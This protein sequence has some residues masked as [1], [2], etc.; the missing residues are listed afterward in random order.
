MC[1]LFTKY[2]LVL[3]I[4]LQIQYADQ[5]HPC[6]A[7]C[8]AQFDRAGH[9]VEPVTTFDDSMFCVRLLQALCIT[10]GYQHE[11]V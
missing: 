10:K 2:W 5:R 4:V 1:N 7:I 8:M 11:R 3:R 6:S 9:G